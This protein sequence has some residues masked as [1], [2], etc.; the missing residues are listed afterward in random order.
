MRAANDVKYVFAQFSS[1]KRPIKDAVMNVGSHLC[2]ANLLIYQP[3]RNE[4]FAFEVRR[5]PLD[6]KF[7]F[8]LLRH[9]HSHLRIISLC[10]VPSSTRHTRTQT[11]NAWRI[12]ERRT[13]RIIKCFGV[14]SPFFRLVLL[15]RCFLCDKKLFSIKS[16]YNLVLIDRKLK[17]CCQH[18]RAPRVE[19]RWYNSICLGEHE[20][21]RRGIE[22]V[23]E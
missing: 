17:N 13:K 14:F 11:A 16:A 23:D 8:M 18:R 1:F 22:I 21:I 2:C 19:R 9:P 3:G 15:P 6:H 4:I 20:G 5:F 7:L 10:M 12:A